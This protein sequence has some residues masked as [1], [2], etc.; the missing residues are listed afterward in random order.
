MT[1]VVIVEARF[2]EDIAEEMAKGCIAVLE[3]AGATSQR[4]PVPGCFEIPAAISFVLHGLAGQPDLPNVDGFVALGCVIRGETT[5][6]DVVCNETARGIQHLAVTHEA[7][8]GFG[9][10][11]VENDEQAWAR[12]KIG[13]KR[14]AGGAAARACL[15]MIE[16][17]RQF[18]LG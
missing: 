10:L 3:K 7:A 8:V 15:R 4:I 14:D 9:I 2:Y 16:L 12:A 5:H 13:G 18:R 6:Y 17:K 11:T 1:H